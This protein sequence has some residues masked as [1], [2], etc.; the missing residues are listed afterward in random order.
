M[1]TGPLEV[2]RESAIVQGCHLVKL[3]QEAGFTIAPKSTLT[4]SSHS[5][6]L[7]IQQGLKANGIYVQ[8]AEGARDVGVD[9][10]AGARRRIT[11]QKSRL[12][13]VRSGVKAVLK[14][15]G[16]V[17]QSR[18]LVLTSIRPRAWGVAAQGASPTMRKGVRRQTM[19][20]FNLRKAGGCI[21]TAFLC[22]GF[23]SKDPESHYLLRM[24]STF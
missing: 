3:L 19:K 24:C 14:M 16:T 9:F 8:V 18:K 17:K 11:L 2:V 20:G 1:F 15:N 12:V 6:A 10:G 7:E 4:A 5:L 21:T 13:K 22:N 23:D